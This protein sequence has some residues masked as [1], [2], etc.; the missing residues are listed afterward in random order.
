MIE[1]DTAACTQAQTHN[2]NK[3]RV[4]YTYIHAGP[5][6]HNINKYK[7]SN[8]CNDRAGHTCNMQAQRYAT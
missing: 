2:K 6:S 7:A 1:R 3:H 8:G 5:K 4:G